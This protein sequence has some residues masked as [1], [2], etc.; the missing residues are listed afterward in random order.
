MRK[1]GYIV[2][3]ILMLI[4]SS[5]M[6][7]FHGSLANGLEAFIFSEIAIYG[8]LIL[9]EVMRSK[10]ESNQEHSQQEKLDDE[11]ELSQMQNQDFEQAEEQDDLQV[12]EQNDV[13]K[14]VQDVEEEKIL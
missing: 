11:R 8:T 1:I 10:K 14:D 4:F 2:L 3:F 5:L 6:I 12:D 7:T 9:F 13:Q